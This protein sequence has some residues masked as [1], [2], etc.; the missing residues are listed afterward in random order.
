MKKNAVV[1][2]NFDG[3][4]KAHAALIS[5]TGRRARERDMN[6]LAFVFENHPREILGGFEGNILTNERKKEI[7]LGLGA[8]SVIYEKFTTHFLNMEPETFARTV[9]AERLCAG[10]VGVG[11]NYSFGK[12][13]E[14]TAE[15]LLEYGRKYG[16]EVYIMPPMLHGDIVISSTSVRC[17]LRAGDMNLV[18]ELCGRPYAIF[19]KV[20]HGM[21]LGTKMGIPTANLYFGSNLAV[22]KSGVYVSRTIIGSKEYKSITNIG[23]NPTVNGDKTHAETHI[24]GFSGE[25]YGEEIMCELCSFLREEIKFSSTE[26]LMRRIKEDINIAVTS[27]DIC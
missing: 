20:E 3:V 8:Q 7:I 27:K 21:Q 22:P 19:G 2:G 14:G 11:Y 9:L 10:L 24:L 23:N 25:I 17:A 26:E 13:G 18:R 1:L 5:E 6:T 15:L 16:F 4:H 12:K